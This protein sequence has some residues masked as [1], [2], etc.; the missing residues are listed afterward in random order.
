MQTDC[1]LIKS[2]GAL[3]IGERA[4]RDDMRRR[5]RDEIVDVVRRIHHSINATPQIPRV[6]EGCGLDKSIVR[7]GHGM[8]TDNRPVLVGR[9]GPPLQNAYDNKHPNTHD[10]P[11]NQ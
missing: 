9:E 2:S 3:G 6:V 1:S 5:Q 10:H 4:L 8:L 11:E 7:Q